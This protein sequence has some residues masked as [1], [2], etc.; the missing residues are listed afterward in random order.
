MRYPSLPRL[1]AI[2]VFAA[3]DVDVVIQ[4]GLGYTPTPAISHAILAYNCGKKIRA[5]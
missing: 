1:L 4:V 2:E 5:V 3:N